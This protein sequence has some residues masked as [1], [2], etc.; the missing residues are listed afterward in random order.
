MN[1]LV[2]SKGLASFVGA[3][4]TAAERL[5]ETKFV[6]VEPMQRPAVEWY[7]DGLE[8]FTKMHKSVCATVGQHQ[9]YQAFRS[10]ISDVR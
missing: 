4:K 10:A 9:H 8:D 7:T 1:L 6:M 2:L 5:P 3:I